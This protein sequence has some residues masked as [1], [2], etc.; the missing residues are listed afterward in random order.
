VRGEKVRL[1]LILA[2]LFLTVPLVG[3]QV[4]APSSDLKVIGTMSE[5]MIRIIY[6]SSDAVFYITTRTPET[7]VQWGELQGQTLMLAE[8]ANILMLPGHARDQE[9]WMADAKLMR[10]AGAAAFK[11]AKA[12]DVKALEAVNDQLYQSCTTCHMHYRRN[13]GRGAAPGR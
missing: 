9:Q 2:V 13:Y 11:A 12:K 5:L 10:D 7:E 6:P 3:A 8:S 1:T 4:A